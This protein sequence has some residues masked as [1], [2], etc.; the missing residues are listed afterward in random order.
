M[1]ATV[2]ALIRHCA[3]CK[4]RLRADNKFDICFA[5]RKGGAAATGDEAPPARRSGSKDTLKRFRVVAHALGRDPD[6]LLAGFA[7]G[8]VRRLQ[9]RAEAMEDDNFQLPSERAAADADD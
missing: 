7:E 9:D 8:W 4:K 6:K 3:N 2:S 1:N 5:C